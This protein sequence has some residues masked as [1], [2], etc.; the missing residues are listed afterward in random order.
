MD[1]QILQPRIP[2]NY[3]TKNGYEDKTTKRVC[4]S[5]SI[6]GSLMGV[7]KRYPGQE[8]YVH[9]PLD[10]TNYY[11]PSTAE[12]PD[13]KITKEVWVKNPVKVKCIGKI[14]VLKD[15]G[16]KGHK[17]KY[18]D[19]VAELYDWEWKWVEK[20]ST[21]TESTLKTKDRNKLDDSEME[22]EIN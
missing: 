11:T 19:K 14:H 2:D 8:Y 1:N 9:V 5:K 22:L 16:L 20:E 17:F 4:F 6:D 21:I 12:V 7:P 3:F 10:D 15:K 18:G 13:S